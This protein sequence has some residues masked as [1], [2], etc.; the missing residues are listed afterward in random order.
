LY[1]LRAACPKG[2]GVRV[3]FVQGDIITRIELSGSGSGNGQDWPG[4]SIKAEYHPAKWQKK[5]GEKMEKLHIGFLFGALV[6]L[7]SR[8]FV[9]LLMCAFAGALN[10]EGILYPLLSMMIWI[11]IFSIFS[12]T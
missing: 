1:L 3:M 2:R 11:Y 6:P 12:F 9:L 8:F 7:Q 10:C 5:A 4:R